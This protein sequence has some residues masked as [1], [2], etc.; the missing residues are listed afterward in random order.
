MPREYDMHDKRHDPVRVIDRPYSFCPMPPN[1]MEPQTFHMTPSSDTEEDS[2]VLRSEIDGTV[3]G[4][5]RSDIVL[6]SA[7]LDGSQPD[8]ESSA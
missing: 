7:W 6:F 1:Q 4:S 3:T 8:L 2:T 5:Y